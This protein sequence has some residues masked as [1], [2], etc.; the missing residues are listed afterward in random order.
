MKTISPLVFLALLIT[1]FSYELVA[2]NTNYKNMINNYVTTTTNSV[3]VINIW[4][5]KQPDD[6]DRLNLLAEKYKNEEIIF[7]AVTDEEQEKVD[8]FLQEQEFAYQHLSGSEGE[9]IFNQ[10]QK[11][12]FKE[13]PIHII[14][15]QEGELSYL[16]KNPIRKIERKLTQRIDDLLEEDST[17]DDIRKS[18]N[19]FTY[20]KSSQK[21]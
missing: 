3:I 5:T 1:V 19:I 13:F 10:F 21:D 14:I 9:K 8:L 17:T 11:G 16:K 15:N 12:M 20:F 7:L 18:T 4:N 6:I 2:Q